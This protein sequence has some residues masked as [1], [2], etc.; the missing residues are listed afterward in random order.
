M[1]PRQVTMKKAF[2]PW[3]CAASVHPHDVDRAAE[4]NP[5]YVHPPAKGHS[6]ILAC[7]MG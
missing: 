3:Q 6:V 7:D 5:A 1:R 2:A 4:P